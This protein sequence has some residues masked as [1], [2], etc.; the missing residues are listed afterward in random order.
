MIFGKREV[1]VMEVLPLFKWVLRLEGNQGIKWDEKE[2]TLGSQCGS[3]KNNKLL[4][5]K[6]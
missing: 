4:G 3:I 2:R 1:V 5:L 6:G